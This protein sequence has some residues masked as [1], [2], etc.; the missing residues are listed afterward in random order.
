MARLVKK[1][2]YAQN[3]EV[4]VLQQQTQQNTTEITNI[5]ATYA[6]NADLAVV[7]QTAHQAEQAAE[8]ATAAGFTGV[9]TAA[10]MD[11]LLI[12]ANANKI[13]RFIGESEGGYEKDQLYQAVMPVGAQAPVWIGQS[14][15]PAGGDV[16]QALMKVGQGQFDLAWGDV[17]G[18]VEPI[19]DS[20]IE[21][22]FG[23]DSEEEGNEQAGE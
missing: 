3:S 2:T 12:P 7:A 23:I 14:F 15:V 20:S 1:T 11:A 9:A 16:G 17:A 13:V 4:V 10:E 21:E 22:L 8:A 19:E 18:E 6:T 5:Q